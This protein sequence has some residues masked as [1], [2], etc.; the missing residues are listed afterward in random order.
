M[1]DDDIFLTYDQDWFTPTPPAPP[2]N[3]TPVVDP[4]LIDDQ[5]ILVD[6]AEHGVSYYQLFNA[7]GEMDFMISI[8]MLILVVGTFRSIQLTLRRMT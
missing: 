8:L 4:N 1:N 5:T 6:F 3:Y 7:N 2:P